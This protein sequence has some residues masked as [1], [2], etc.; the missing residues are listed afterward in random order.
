[1]VTILIRAI[2]LAVSAPFQALAAIRA[3]KTYEHDPYDDWAE[4]DEGR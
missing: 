4:H 2:E 3:A 1:M